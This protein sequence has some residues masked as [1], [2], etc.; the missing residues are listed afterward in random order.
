D[1]II[2]GMSPTAERKKEIAFTNPYYE[3]Q[4]VVIVKKDGKYANAKSLKD[5]ADAKITAQ[6]N[7]FHYGLI[8]QIP[9][10]NKQQAMDNFS[11]MRT[12]LASG[13]IDGYVSERPEGIT[14]TSVNKELKMLEFPKENGF[15]ASAEDSQVAVGMRKGDPDIEKV[16]KILAGISQDERTKIMDQAIK[17]QPAA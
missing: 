6:L 8:D 10:V 3:S 16:N 11:A 15:D 5:L 7:T 14:A 9:N 12:A 17:D 13:M 2:A 4:F 1:A